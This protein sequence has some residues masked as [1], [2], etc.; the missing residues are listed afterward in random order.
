MISPVKDIIL[1]GTIEVDERLVNTQ[2]AHFGGRIEELFIDY[3]GQYVERGDPVARVYSPAIFAAQQELI[4]A[5][6]IK[7]EAPDIYKA[8]REK[9]RL[10]KIDPQEIDEIER[11]GNI[12]E[13]IK[14]M[15]DFSGYVIGLEVSD[16][17]SVR[18]G[19]P[20]MQIAALNRVW[21]ILD[22]YESDLQ[23]LRNGSRVIIESEAY[24]DED[25]SGRIS[26]IDPVIDRNTRTARARVVLANPSGMLKPGMFV[27][28]NVKYETGNKKILAIPK[29]AVMWTGIR[30][31]VYV[32]MPDTETP[33]FES[34]VV[35][36]GWDFGD[37]YEIIS[38]LE[39]GENVVSEGTFNLD[40]AAQLNNKRSMMNA[41]IAVQ[42]MEKKAPSVPDFRKST[43]DK[44]KEQL[45]DVVEEYLELSLALVAADE[46]KAKK[47][48]EKLMR[49]FGETD[50]GLLGHVP[51]KY[52]MEAADSMKLTTRKII[53]SEKLDQKRAAFI[54]LSNNIIKSVKAFGVDKKLFLQFC[55]MA[56]DDRGAYWLSAQKEIL[57]P[58]FGDMMLH[59][60]ETKEEIEPAE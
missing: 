44:F 35:E 5:A 22:V 20:M 21:A 7:D 51:H 41:D 6:A 34:R 56:D 52:W 25:F 28:G 19:Q 58:Y 15:A 26:Y 29:S 42:G 46:T 3:T 38:G 39:P 36:L 55:P 17:N 31:L 4:E 8:A 2:I 59:C 49:E 57:N 27:S 16:G 13:S 9:L 23:F 12:R 10:M 54:G 40:A 33:V 32:E 1:H 48:A 43:P 24:P 18:Q 11:S 60:G 45:R 53:D 47:S 14:I 37:K 30:S 50:M